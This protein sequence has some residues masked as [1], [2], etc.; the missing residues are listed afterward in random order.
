MCHGLSRPGLG[1]KG[2]FRNIVC[3]NRNFLSQEDM[4]EINCIKYSLIFTTV[5]GSSARAGHI[6]HKVVVRSS[7]TALPYV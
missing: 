6:L 7:D 5:C 2:E 3:P 1:S 4:N